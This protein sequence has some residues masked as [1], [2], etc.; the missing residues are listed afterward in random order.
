MELTFI[1]IALFTEF[2]EQKHCWLKT[3]FSCPP[4]G[5]LQRTSV[6]AV[7]STPEEIVDAAN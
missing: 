4:A 3:K 2:V 6:L 7:N 1:A 5:T